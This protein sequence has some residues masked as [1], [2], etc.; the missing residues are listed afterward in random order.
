MTKLDAC[1]R[2]QTKSGRV[3]NH[4]TITMVI[5]NGFTTNTFK[6]N[7]SVIQPQYCLRRFK[8]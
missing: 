8:R 7:V 6:R 2:D 3:Q 1:E 5:S 4:V